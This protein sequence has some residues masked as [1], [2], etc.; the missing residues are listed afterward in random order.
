MDQPMTGA[1]IEAR[2]AV[3]LAG[4]R[5]LR[6]R[7]V[8]TAEDLSRLAFG[9]VVTGWQVRTKRFSSRGAVFWT[10]APT[11]CAP[12][13]VFLFLPESECIVGA[14]FEVGKLEHVSQFSLW[15]TF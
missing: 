1:E 8:Q 3:D 10:P 15:E 13:H 4:L 6:A 14:R 5:M 11:F 7:Q 9:Q 12:A 2:H